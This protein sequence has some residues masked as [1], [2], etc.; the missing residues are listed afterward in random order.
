M[1][2][3]EL[4]IEDRQYREDEDFRHIAWCIG[5]FAWGVPVTYPRL[6]RHDRVL[7]RIRRKEIIN[8]VPG[9]SSP[10][11]SLDTAGILHGPNMPYTRPYRTV[12]RSLLSCILTSSIGQVPTIVLF[13][14]RAT[15]FGNSLRRGSQF[16]LRDS[17][18]CPGSPRSA[19]RPEPPSEP[20]ESW[21]PGLLAC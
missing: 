17:G 19:H 21:V 8:P 18:C 5:I 14:N 16:L 6:Q 20:G 3:K 7:Y 4:V 13:Y 2:W 1:L 12:D 15:K 10:C 9:A 11:L